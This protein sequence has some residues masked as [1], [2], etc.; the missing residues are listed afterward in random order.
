MFTHTNNLKV[1][2]NR[3]LHRET[4]MKLPPHICEPTGTGY[5]DPISR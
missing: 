4:C 2:N 3:Q 5:V 1:D